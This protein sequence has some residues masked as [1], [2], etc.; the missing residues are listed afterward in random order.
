MPQGPLGPLTPVTMATGGYVNIL[1]GQWN[2][3]EGDGVDRLMLFHCTIAINRSYDLAFA[4]TNPRHLR[5][6]LPYGIGHQY[7]KSRAWDMT[8][9]T[10]P[11]DDGGYHRKSQEARLVIGIFY[12][13]PEK[14]EVHMAAP[15]LHCRPVRDRRDQ[16]FCNG[17]C[18]WCKL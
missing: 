11:I 1:N 4:S 18:T 2:R 12:S 15:H 16:N 3:N 6:R 5:L 8:G 9:E 13:N 7:N 17:K 10:L 14:V